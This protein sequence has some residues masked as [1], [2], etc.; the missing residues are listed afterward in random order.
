[1]AMLDY[2]V[3]LTLSPAKCT[4]ADIQNLRETGFEDEQILLINLTTSYFNFVN[5]LAHGLGVTLE[6]DHTEPGSS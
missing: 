4:E 2:A 3:K 6:T 1:M 5:R